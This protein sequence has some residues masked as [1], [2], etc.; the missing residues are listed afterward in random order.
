MVG[1]LEA[2]LEIAPGDAAIEI[3][4]LV[5]AVGAVW[6][7]TRSSF[8]FWVTLSSASAKPATAITMR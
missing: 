2:A 4:L 8:S 3:L 5:L 1:E 6:P 7:V